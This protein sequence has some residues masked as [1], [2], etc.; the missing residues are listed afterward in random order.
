MTE[1]EPWNIV[2]ADPSATSDQGQRSKIHSALLEWYRKHGRHHLPWRHTRDSYAIL[3]AEIMLQQTQ[4]ER[5]L[6]KYNAFLERFPTFSALAQAPTGEVIKAWAGLG[7]NRRAVQLQ[8][9]ARQVVSTFA[10]AL[11]GTIEELLSLR[12]VG[13]YTAGAIACF[14]FGLPVATVDT[15]IR[16]VLW[17]LFTGTTTAD[18]R[19]RD[20]ATREILALA[21]W[22][23][24][25]DAAYEWQQALMDLGATVCLGRRPLCERCPLSNYCRAY[26]ETASLT[27]FPSGE[28]VGRLSRV[29]EPHAAYSAAT[30]RDTG[31]RR[32][33]MKKRPAFPQSSRYF[34]GR[35]VEILCSLA[36]DECLLLP[37]LGLRIRP[38]FAEDPALT[39]WLCGILEGLA[40]DGL[41]RLQRVVEGVEC[42]EAQEELTK[43][44]QADAHRLRVA[45]P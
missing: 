12:G 10:G 19:A 3:V 14:A 13:R 24:P 9:I 28:A 8:E 41:V 25:P 40:H 15:N 6:P 20:H 44:T 29:A 31:H 17:R 33:A 43:I 4:V 39:T 42:Q 38:D 37:D 26:A 27:L 45:L 23:I 2:L 22:A 1:P 7:Y 36:P 16:R 11:P 5:V 30:S 18:G 34:R 35:V 21:G 32:H